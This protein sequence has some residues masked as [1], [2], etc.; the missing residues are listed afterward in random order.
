MIQAKSA[1]KVVYFKLQQLGRKELDEYFSFYWEEIYS[2]IK[3][4]RMVIANI[5]Y[6]DVF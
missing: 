5:G 4:H 2:L 1:P 6:L 3:T